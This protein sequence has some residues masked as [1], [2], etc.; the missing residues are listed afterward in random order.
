MSLF[1]CVIADLEDISYEENYQGQMESATYIDLNQ[2]P[3]ENSKYKLLLSIYSNHIYN[4]EFD[5]K[6][7]IYFIYTLFIGVGFF[8]A[9]FVCPFPY[10]NRVL[11]QLCVYVIYMCMSLVVLQV[12]SFDI[13][14]M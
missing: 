1:L 2:P 9:M 3:L 7:A 11:K 13:Y 4:V 8:P 14:N 6:L 5:L 10:K 12:A